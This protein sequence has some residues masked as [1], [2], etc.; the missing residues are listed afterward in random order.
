[1]NKQQ[2]HISICTCV[3][4][5][6]T[7]YLWVSEASTHTHQIHKTIRRQGAYTFS[8]KKDNNTTNIHQ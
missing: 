1:M 2:K 7:N 4:K 8:D 5:K 3:E 6:V